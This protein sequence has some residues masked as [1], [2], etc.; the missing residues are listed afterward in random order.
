MEELNYFNDKII[1]QLEDLHKVK[2]MAD[3]V[4]VRTRWVLCNKGDADNPD[5]RAR[6]VA[7]EVNKTGKE[8]A[9]WASTP[10]GESKKILFSMYASRRNATIANGT[11]PL[12]LSFIDIK[13]AYFNGV[14]T[15]DIYMSLPAEIGLPKHF[16][17]KQTKCVYGTRDAG[18]IWESC[19]RKAL[20]DMGFVTG[21]SN[22]CLFAHAERGIQV[23]VHGDDFTA[24]G[25]DDDLD[26]YTAELEKVF[27]IK[28]R[29]RL[30]EGTADTEIRILNRV[31]R[32][33]SQGVSYEADPRHH[34]LLQRSLGLE[35]STPVSTPGVKATAIEAHTLKGEEGEIAGPVMDQTGRLNTPSEENGIV[36]VV[37]DDSI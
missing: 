27:E 25:T 4:N 16:I 30:G 21:V 12:Q 36:N 17:A 7:C 29:G 26:W 35:G 31:I 10:P 1:W 19:Y 37:E 28:V 6:L 34:E 22:P 23:V 14:P 15:R 13:K 3:V 18:M 33:T 20:E 32:I 11:A 5:M 24:L 8:D 9:S 2:Q